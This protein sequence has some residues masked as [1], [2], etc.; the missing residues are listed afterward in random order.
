MGHDGKDGLQNWTYSGD[1][2]PFYLKNIPFLYFGVE[3]HIDY[4]KP[5]DDFDNINPEFFKS[6][7]GTIINIFS[8]LD[9]SSL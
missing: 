5:T 6:S 7:V 3:D 8:L 9:S 1:H 2:G 4:H